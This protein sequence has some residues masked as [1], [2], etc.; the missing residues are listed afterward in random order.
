MPHYL[1]L[2]LGDGVIINL[3]VT[4]NY[5]ELN[6]PKILLLKTYLEEFVIV[7]GSSDKTVKCTNCGAEV[8][9]GLKFCTECGEPIK[10]ISADYD[11]YDQ[12]KV[13]PKCYAEFSN[14]LMYCSECGTK[15]EKVPDKSKFIICKKCF[16]EIPSDSKFCPEC[17]SNIESTEKGTSLTTKKSA[18]SS[19][20]KEALKRKRETKHEHVPQSEAS[21]S[22]VKSNKGLMNEIGGFPDKKGSKIDKNLES[23][24]DNASDDKIYA[25]IEKK[26]NIKDN[27]GFLVCDKCG[28]YYE[29]QPGES[30][31]DFIDKCECGGKLIHKSDLSC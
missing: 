8:S 9:E 28:G 15:L 30:P 25:E 7:K 26:R 1:N 20:I 3:F 10:N 23:K 29:L 17:A 2:Q 22:L 24:S 11:K 14:D 6:I 27:P 21:D 5:L 16:S 12:K 4:G 18:K 13:C 31:E 19:Y